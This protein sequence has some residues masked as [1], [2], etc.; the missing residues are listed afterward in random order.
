MR[1]R[2]TILATVCALFAFGLSQMNVVVAASTAKVANPALRYALSV[3]HGAN[4]RYLPN[5]LP[6]PMLSGGVTES[7]REIL[8]SQSGATKIAGAG[9]YVPPISAT[10]NG[11]PNVFHKNGYPANIRANQDCTL[12]RQAEEQLAVNPTDPHNIVVGQNDSR[13]GYNQTG[14]DYTTNN[15]ANWGDYSVPTRFTACDGYGYD[16]FSDPALAI[17]SSGSMSYV[18]VGFDVF[19]ATSGL[20]YWSGGYK[21]SSL[22]SPTS[23]YSATPSIIYDNCSDPTKSPDKQFVTTD[24]S[25]GPNDGNI[26]VTFTLFQSDASGNYLSSPIYFSKSTDGGLSWSPIK[27]ISGISSTVCV[28]GD[29]FD[30]NANPHACNFDQGSIPVVGPD[31]TINVAFNNCNTE[32]AAASGIGICQ[33]LFVKSTDGGSTWSKPVKIGDDYAQQP[34]NLGQLGAGCPFGRQCLPPNGYRMNDFPAMGIDD[35]T[36]KLGVFWS[37]FRNGCN[38]QFGCSGTPNSNQDVVASVSTNGGATWGATKIVDTNHAAQWQAWGDVGENGK[39][40]VGYY[41]RK[42][43]HSEHSGTN[44][45]TLA[46]SGNNGTTW[47]Y[48]RI[49]THAMPNLTPSNNPYQA[50]FLGDY[51][52]TMYANGNVYLVW[53][54]TRGLQ[55]TVEEDVYYAKVGACGYSC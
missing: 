47:T 30:Q 43:R 19:N 18:A 54:D 51:M 53:A 8:A 25:G 29:F 35:N 55:N 37:D 52:W 48:E 34:L 44:N 3:G 41:D 45:I 32:D 23:E 27:A 33:Q 5:G 16:A 31:G 20:A 39:L 12:R 26:Y 13:V 50:G 4:L 1:R 15:A 49:T 24:N 10:T 36:G 6:V 28:H 42:Y 22:H 11:C 40:Y 21:G 14:V 46:T 9:T 2:A 7:A 17:N 38:P